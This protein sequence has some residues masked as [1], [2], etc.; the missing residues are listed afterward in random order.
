MPNI[1]IDRTIGFLWKMPMILI[2]F[3]GGSIQYFGILSQ[4]QSNWIALFLFSHVFFRIAAWRQ[5]KYEGI[6][7]LFLLLVV[8]DHSQHQSPVSYALTYFYYIACTI[9]AAVAGR[10]YALRIASLVS[11]ESYFKVAKLF[12]FVELIVVIIQR[13]FTDQ[14]ISFARAPIGYTDAIFGTFFL[15]SDATLA[16]VCELLTISAFFLHCKATDRFVI[17]ALS[18]AVIFLGN[19]NTAKMATILIFTLLLVHYIYGRLHTGR[20]G[21]NIIATL[22]VAFFIMIVYSPASTFFADFFA[23]AT[24]DYYRRD[25]WISASRFAPMGQIFAEGIDFF[26]Q[27]ALTYYNP[28]TKI[29]LYD[30]GFSTIYSLYLDFGIIGL[31]IYLLYQFV[32]IFRFAKNYFEFIIFAC[33]FIFFMTFN[34][35]LT[36]LT[37][38][39]SFNVIL[40]LNHLRGR[41]VSRARYKRTSLPLNGE[42]SNHVV[43]RLGG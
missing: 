5:I 41:S 34:F 13:S 4:T 28:I 17:S 7:F 29:W 18:F 38:V 43:P 19:S 8:L 26:G 36:D 42:F 10:V 35:A 37:F 30:A 16:A 14:F 15:Q 1:A 2:F 21:F 33:V 11:T 22:V 9:I 23:K 24:G 6:L 27:G 3:V 40:C 20:Y 25:A 39:F 31:S 32:L 12:L